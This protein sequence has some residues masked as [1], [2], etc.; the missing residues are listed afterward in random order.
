MKYLLLLALL[1]SAN[2][3]FAQGFFDESPTDPAVW[4]SSAQDTNSGGTFGG[5]G[6]TDTT[7]GGTFQGGG[8]QNTTS[9]GTF[10]GGG[11][12]NTTSGGTFTGGGN[13]N[14]SSGGTFTGGLK[15]LNKPSLT[16]VG[17][18]NWFVQILNYI[19]ILL[20]TASLVVFMYGVFLLMF[21]KGTDVE[22]RAKG[23]QFMMWGIISLFVMTSTW[24]LVNILKSSIF[25][26]TGGLSGPQ[27]K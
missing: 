25:G 11:N 4:N 14:T 7:S 24:G 26:S 13:Q 22:S 8:N 16:I 27:F 20:F 3:S 15:E 2:V 19:S 17:I 18:S 5:S 10:T 12:Q 23:R 1:C 9:G 21:V 6:N